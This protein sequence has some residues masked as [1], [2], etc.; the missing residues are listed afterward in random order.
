MMGGIQPLI[1][2]GGVAERFGMA[3]WLLLYR[4]ERGELPGPSITVAGRR[5]FTE[6][7]VQ[8]IALALHERPELR[9]GRAARGEGG[10]HAQA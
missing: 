10:D 9:V 5:L 3:R 6:A 8:R 1:G 7:D 2:S 4:I